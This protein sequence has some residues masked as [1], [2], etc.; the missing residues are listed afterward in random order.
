MSPEPHASD[1][2][3]WDVIVVG[4]GSAGAAVAVQTARIG[5]R[6]L[7]L[8]KHPLD[9]AGAT[10]VN[11]VH[12]QAFDEAGLAR[13]T[14]PELRAAGHR[15]HLVA[16]WGPTTKAVSD[17]GV[18]DIDMRLLIARL[19]HEARLAGAE[20]RGRESVLA[21]GPGIVTT[22]S[23]TLRAA[24]VVDACGLGGLYRVQKPRPGD[25]CAAAQGVYAVTDRPAA[26]A[27]FRSFGAEP[28]ETLCF[29]AVAGGYS[30]ASMRME[31]DELAI[32]TGT[33]PALGHPAG[34]K[35]RD[36]LAARHA[37]IGPMAFG[38][39]APIPLHRPRKDLAFGDDDGA[40]VRVGDAAGLVYAAHGSGIGAQL[41]AGRMLADALS[42]HG[43]RPGL[44]SGLGRAVRA[45]ERAWHRRFGA[46]FLVADAF[47]RLSTRL[48]P[49]VLA[50]VL[51]SGLMP[52]PLLRVG[53]TAGL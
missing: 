22:A 31:G 37:W 10:W 49:E 15:F 35:V 40:L 30:I 29:A 39:H 13:P 23:A 50:W 34:K 26:E 51:R 3:G 19:Q 42:A 14:A 45:W 33:L 8:D 1:A 9:R 17:T 20:L 16:G 52:E 47:R 18:L 27:F 48:T 28:G 36:D 25:V 53:F 24:L 12:G 21:L 2:S 6:T 43:L 41:V 32:L 5:L 44:R 46:R 7:V 11:G 4:A 38:G